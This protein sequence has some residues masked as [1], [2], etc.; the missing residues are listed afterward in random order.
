MGDAACDSL[1][2]PVARETLVRVTVFNAIRVFLFFP[3]LNDLCV[4]FEVLVYAPARSLLKCCG[5]N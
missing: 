5:R 2:S 1:E 3:P 4:I